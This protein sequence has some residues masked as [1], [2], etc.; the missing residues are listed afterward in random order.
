M[1]YKDAFGMNVT[2]GNGEAKDTNGVVDVTHFGAVKQI[3]QVFDFDKDGIP[4]CIGADNQ[5]TL[6]IRSSKIP[7]GSVIVS[8]RLAVLKAA[9]TPATTLD[10]GLVGLDAMEIDADGLIAG[11]TCAAGL[12]T[13]EGALIGAAPLAK[14]GYI[15][16]D[17]SADTAAALGGLVAVLI[18][19]YV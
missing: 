1:T 12:K 17:P 19:E 4:T 8:A 7:A 14:D 11:A 15:V 10:Y 18:V 2:Y 9:A 6:T 13:G 16:V 5:S 3:T